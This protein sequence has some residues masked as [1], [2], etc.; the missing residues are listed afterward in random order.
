MSEYVSTRGD[1]GQIGYE[2]AILRGLAPD[3]G[4]YVPTEYPVVDLDLLRKMA[5]MQYYQQFV[6]I[7]SLFVGDDI[8]IAVQRSIAVGTYSRDIF[9]MPD[10]HTMTP[11]Q[12]LDGRIVVQQLSLGP[13]AAFKDMA[14]QPL[15]R[16][17]NYA[18]DRRGET[19]RML[20]ATSGDT[21]SA[22][23][24][25]IKGKD[26]M[27]LTMLSPTEG[28][29]DFQKAQMAELSGD[30]IMNISVDG[31]F[32]DCQD[33]VKRL[34]SMPE[35]ADLGAVNSI[36]WGRIAAQVPY[37]FSGYL[38][39]ARDNMSSPA[40]GS[41]VD[42]VV[43]SGNFGNVLAGHI[44]KKMGLPIRRLIV[45]TNEND[46]LNG[47]VEQGVYRKQGNAQVTSSPS[48]DIT[49]ASNYERVLGDVF[50][51]D[52][53]VVRRYMEKFEQKGF[54]TFE[55]F[56]ASPD[57][58]KQLGF[59]SGSSTHADR[60]QSMRYAYS[61]CARVIDPHTADAVAVARRI[62]SS[63]DPLD[64]TPMVCMSTALPVKF[65]GTVQEALGFVA[66]RP[67][68]FVDLEKRARTLG[69]RGFSATIAS[70]DIDSLARLIRTF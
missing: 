27:S 11:V 22:A 49:T 66:E 65:E 68:R 15:S 23:E 36:N 6:A 54:V 37:Y 16:H 12:W 14:L 19:L 63:D 25:A 67:A 5:E 46:V 29:S 10:R 43:P 55:E 8:P 7:N 17:L 69:S 60:I 53:D 42:F 62:I 56:G 59:V 61:R 18:L 21:G 1:G 50:D 34:K 38:E 20:G 2:E 64:M 33:M 26:T 24:A 41:E 45:A 70:G 4:L 57:S 9:D 31:R 39:I 47:V 48:M 3:R 40:I 13:T 44:A 35:F 52:S 30:N 32:D 58:M 28:M 51:G